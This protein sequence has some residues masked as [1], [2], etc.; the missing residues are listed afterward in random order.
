M[1]DSFKLIWPIFLWVGGLIIFYFIDRSKV[2]EYFNRKI[3]TLSNKLAV[4]DKDLVPRED[5]Q[6]MIDSNLR[7]LT[8]SMSSL[9]ESNK[10]IDGRLISLI[11]SSASNEVKIASIEKS[12]E[13]KT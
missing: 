13:N 2:K 12:L 5:V 10:T 8:K 1:I 7:V 3:D 9:C 4:V 6:A 11:K